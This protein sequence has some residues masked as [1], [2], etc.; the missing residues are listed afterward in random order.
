MLIPTSTGTGAVRDANKSS[1]GRVTID[2]NPNVVE[3]GALIGQEILTADKVAIR[4]SILVQFSV[5]DPKAA[6][7]ATRQK[8]SDG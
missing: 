6:L 2:W 1:G 7:D 4:M 5:V 8:R 3:V